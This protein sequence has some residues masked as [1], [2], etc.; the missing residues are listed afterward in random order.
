MADS[1]ALI[2]G[3]VDDLKCF[4]NVLSFIYAQF[5]VKKK[6]GSNAEESVIRQNLFFVNHTVRS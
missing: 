2:T 6:K 1:I 3:T 4:F 5:E